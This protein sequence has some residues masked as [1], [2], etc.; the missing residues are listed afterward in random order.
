MKPLNIE[1]RR[2][3][4]IQYLLMYLITTALLVYS[5]CM[6]CTV[7]DQQNRFLQDE[8]K[9]L[10]DVIHATDAHNKTLND[11]NVLVLKIDSMSYDD[12]KDNV[13]VLRSLKSDLSIAFKKD[14]AIMGNPLSMS[15]LN[16]V[17]V[18]R[19]TLSAKIQLMSEKRDVSKLNNNYNS[20]RNYAE[21]LRKQL[22]DAGIEPKPTPILEQ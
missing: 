3:A 7:P 10:H 16:A 9:K 12:L 13:E 15:Y 17:D 5:I 20:L 18:L 8:N 19:S 14:S 1:E 11:L 4:F 2:K 6:V 21:S 22:T